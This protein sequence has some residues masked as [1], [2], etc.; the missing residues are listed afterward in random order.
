M[1]VLSSADFV[2]NELF[3]KYFGNTISVLNSLDPD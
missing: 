1:F 2:K 3:K